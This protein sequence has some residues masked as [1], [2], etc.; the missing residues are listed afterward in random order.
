MYTHSREVGVTFEVPGESTDGLE[1][2][3]VV[4][5]IRLKLLQ[6][7]VAGPAAQTVRESRRVAA[8]PRHRRQ[9]SRRC[10]TNAVAPFSPLRSLTNVQSGST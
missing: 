6:Q 1:Q 9:R 7:L 10:A 4:H 8:K 5:E 2:R 3:V